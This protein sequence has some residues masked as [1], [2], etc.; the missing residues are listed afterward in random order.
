LLH[1]KISWKKLFFEKLVF[2]KSY[3][4]CA[5]AAKVT[6]YYQIR[7]SIYGV[8]EKGISFWVGCKLLL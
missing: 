6:W 4:I 1:K 7:N 8:L 3:I 5:E 2:S